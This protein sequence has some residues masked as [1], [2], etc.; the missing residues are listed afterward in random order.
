MVLWEDVH[1]SAQKKDGDGRG[2]WAQGLFCRLFFV[3][4][5]VYYTVRCASNPVLYLH[6]CAL[7]RFVGLR[8]QGK[9][10][11]VWERRRRKSR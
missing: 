1:S 10:S 2:R 8:P 6:L 3:G 7:K 4:N 9:H 11:L 5:T